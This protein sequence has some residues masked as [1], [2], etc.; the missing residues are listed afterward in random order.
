MSLEE[1]ESRALTANS[2]A[3]VLE[4]LTRLR[5]RRDQIDLLITDRRM[6]AID[7]RLLARCL[8]RE[9]PE[10]AVLFISGAGDPSELGEFKNPGFLGKPF[11]PSRL[12][13]EVNRLLKPNTAPSAS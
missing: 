11:S 7:G 1:E 2:G 6:P 5:S 3:E 4:V 10:L 12:L 13:T 8:A 9:D